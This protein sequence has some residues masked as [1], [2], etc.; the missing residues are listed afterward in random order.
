MDLDIRKGPEVAQTE[1]TGHYRILIGFRAGWGSRNPI[2]CYDLV[3]GRPH[4]DHSIPSLDSALGEL[5][6]REFRILDHH[7]K[8]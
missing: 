1:I 8:Y 4:I 2:S 3:V 6:Y 5:Q 7:Y